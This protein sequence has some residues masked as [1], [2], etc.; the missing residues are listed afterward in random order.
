MQQLPVAILMSGAPGS[1]KSTL[2]TLLGQ[3]LCLPV[4]DKDT[5]RRATLWRLGVD[6]VN[7]AP[8]G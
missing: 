6:D 1:G 3:R 2:A 4:V 8:W 5:L 7:T